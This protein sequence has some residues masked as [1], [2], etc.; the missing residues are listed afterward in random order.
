MQLL[1]RLPEQGFMPQLPLWR[2][3]F[4][5]HVTACQTILRL[6]FSTFMPACLPLS[7]PSLPSHQTSFCLP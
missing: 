3:L 5:E 7:T 1:T 4:D 2:L 6:P